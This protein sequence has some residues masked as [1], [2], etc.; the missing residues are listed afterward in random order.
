MNNTS[1]EFRFYYFTNRYQETV[2][3]YKNILHLDVMR[4]WDR[5]AGNRGTIF[6]SFNGVGLIEI[7]EGEKLPVIQGALYIQITYVDKW[8][9]IVTKN[10]IKVVQPLSDTT[11]GH[12]NFKFEDPS[13][14][15]IGLFNYISE[16]QNMLV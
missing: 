1:P 9:E 4:S 3:F 8:Y 2:S 10:N 11:Y 7:E 14:M 6:H 13:G 16:I 12:R 5:G 15:T